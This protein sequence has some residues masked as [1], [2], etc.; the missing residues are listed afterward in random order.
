VLLNLVGVVGVLVLAL[1][2]GHR[3]TIVRNVRRRAEQIG[4]FVLG[5]L[6]AVALLLLVVVV[7]AA[8]DR[9]AP[10]IPLASTFSNL[11]AS[12]GKIES[13]QDRVT[14]ASVA[15]S[16][17]HQ[18]PVIG[19]GLGVEFQYYEA[20]SRSVKTIAYAHN[21]VLD[22]WLRLG[23]IGVLLF[24]AALVTSIVGGLKVWRRQADRITATMA[25]ALV[26]VVT[27]LIVTAFFEPLIDEYRLATILGVSLGMLRAT[28]TAAGGSWS[29]T[30]P[31]RSELGAGTF[32][33]GD[34]R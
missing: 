5:A 29:G 18:H 2:V 30:T 25:L 14:L 4:R 8:V 10:H 32:S 1:L 22:I 15:E 34:K 20:G 23:I 13:A 33:T 6:A 7:P 27:G 12:Q 17:I 3:H 28:V 26:A 24:A 11:F 19:W 21:I 9:E 16:M 31:R